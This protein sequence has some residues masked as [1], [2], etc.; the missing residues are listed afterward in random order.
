[1][2]LLPAGAAAGEPL[3][4]DEAVELALE[5]SRAIALARLALKEA[6]LKAQ[7]VILGG[8]S[9]SPQERESA[10]ESV[11]SARTGLA[12]AIDNAVLT[13]EER[14]YA[15]LQAQRA[16]G[17]AERDDAKAAREYEIASLRF[18]EGLISAMQFG[19]ASRQRQ[20]SELNLLEARQNLEA[21]LRSFNQALGID[22]ETKWRLESR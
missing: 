2:A 8:A 13:V 11:R 10:E 9:V 22:L 15:V 6:E 1:S 7:Q 5:H 14:H 16:L 17:L 4:L 20:Q 3:S 21:S 12:D 19:D 18:E